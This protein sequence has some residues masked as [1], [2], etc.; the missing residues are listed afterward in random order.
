MALV[1]PLANPYGWHLYD[2]LIRY[3][4]NSELLAR[5]AEFQSFDFQTAGSGQ[6]IATVILGIAGGTLAFL[7]RRWERFALAMTISVMALRSARALPLAALVLLPLADGEI[8]VL[9]KGWNYARR[10][11]EMDA[12]FS[13]VALAPV[14]IAAAFGLLRF[15][16]AGFPPDQ[17]PVQAYSHIPA[18]AR[19]FAPD[20]YG[21]YL[22]YRSAGARKVS[23]DGRSDFYG[24]EFLKQYGR[25]VQVRPGWREH[26]DSFG[27]SH[28]LMPND[29]PLV[30][31]LE[32]IGWRPIYRD[33]TATLLARAGT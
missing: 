13:G 11:R 3:L 28:A 18:E 14:A 32:L 16:P 8:N 12:R 6:I 22:I 30:S 29:Y 33:G 7:H 23:F 19:L 10:L 21:G 4:T 20:R 15:F 27:F 25:M 9:L 24:V 31:A 26:W 5:I 17:F 2:H 1:A